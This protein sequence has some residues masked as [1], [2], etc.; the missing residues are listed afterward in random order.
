M[1]TETAATAPAPTMTLRRDSLT[2]SFVSMML[3]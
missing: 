3:I 1:A 2:M